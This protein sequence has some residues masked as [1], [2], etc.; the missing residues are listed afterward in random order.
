M[1]DYLLHVLSRIQST[2]LSAQSPLSPLR[3]QGVS[4]EDKRACPEMPRHPDQPTAPPTPTEGNK[5]DTVITKTFIK[6]KL[7]FYISEIGKEIS[8]VKTAHCNMLNHLQMHDLIGTS[9][10]PCNVGRVGDY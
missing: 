2:G 9:Q 5:G 10:S 8:T 6:N 7:Y 1:Q 4:V 3:A